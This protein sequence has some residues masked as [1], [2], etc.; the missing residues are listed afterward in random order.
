MAGSHLS[1]FLPQRTPNPSLHHNSLLHFDP[2][3]Y[4]G[5]QFGVF[6][7]SFSKMQFPLLRLVAFLPCSAVTK[8]PRYISP[9]SLGATG[10]R[11][12]F[13]AVGR[14]Y[15]PAGSHP[16]RWISP[17]HIKSLPTSLMFSLSFLVVHV[18]F[19]QPDPRD[20]QICHNTQPPHRTYPLYPHIV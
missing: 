12:Q 16:A 6:V 19:P 18:S 11:F 15:P 4:H 17:C 5:K 10:S 14:A 1:V 3:T 7:N 2:C 20:S 8:S 9:S 13:R